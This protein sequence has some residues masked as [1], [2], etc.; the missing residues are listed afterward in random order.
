[1]S[2]DKKLSKPQISKIIKSDGFLVGFDPTIK[3]WTTTVKISHKTPWFTKF[4]SSK[5]SN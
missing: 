5:L 2:T 4:N 3:N 1:M